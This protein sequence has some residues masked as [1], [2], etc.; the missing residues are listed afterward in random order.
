MSFDQSFPRKLLKQPP[1]ARLDYFRALTISH[2]LLLQAYD[3]LRRAIRD[4]KPGSIILM[5]GPAGVGKTTLLQMAENDIREQLLPELIKDVGRLPVI[6]IE[7]IPPG[8]SNFHW[9]DYFRRL[10]IALEEPE[11]FID[12][13]IIQNQAGT[14]LRHAVEQTLLQRHPLAVLIDDIQHLGS[15]AKLLDQI[16]TIKSI[17]GL[18]RTT[19]V[20]TSTYQS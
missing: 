7:A 20:L 13:K 4:S 18:T 11:S 2:P 8:S 1:R 12:R 10:M 17:A 19:H 14:T 5:Q 3:D 16:R 15:G 9:E 6:R